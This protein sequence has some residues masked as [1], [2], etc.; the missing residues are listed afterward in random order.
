M[1]VAEEDSD[2]QHPIID[3]LGQF[4]SE[5]LGKSH[6]ISPQLLEGVENHEHLPVTIKDQ[7]FALGGT[8]LSLCVMGDVAFESQAVGVSEKD[9]KSF[10]FSEERMKEQLKK[11]RKVISGINYSEKVKCLILGMIEYKKQ[12]RLCP[13]QILKLI[14]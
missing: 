7:I 1:L 13:D 9:V 6:W 4:Q 11:A 3:Y 5:N 10:V 12:S 2:G 14:N 8:V